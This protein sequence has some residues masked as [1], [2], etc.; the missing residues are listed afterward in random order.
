MYPH[1]WE[2]R[3]PTDIQWAP[4]ETGKPGHENDP[5]ASGFFSSQVDFLKFLVL[6]GQ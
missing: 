6:R 4:L 5:P 3:Q 1:D 2:A